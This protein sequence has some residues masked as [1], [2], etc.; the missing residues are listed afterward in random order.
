MT[1]S[2]WNEEKLEK[3]L[4]SMP[5]V[6]DDRD[7]D[8]LYE[9]VQQRTQKKKSAFHTPK[10]L[11]PSAAGVAILLIVALIVPQYLP[12]KN[13]ESALDSKQEATQLDEANMPQMDQQNGQE[14][15]SS[16]EDSGSSTMHIAGTN[17]SNILYEG[18]A[19][20]VI[21]FGLPDPEGKF[22][23][24]F[25][26]LV[27]NEEN[28]ADLL[29][30][31]SEW[32]D[33]AQYGLDSFVFANSDLAIK[34][35]EPGTMIID[36][37]ADH[38]FRFGSP[39]IEMLEMTVKT[40]QYM[41][42]TSA[43]LKT[44]GNPGIENEFYGEIKEMEIASLNK[45]AYFVYKYDGER[46]V[47]VPMPVN[48]PEAT[49]EKALEMMKSG[50]ANDS[51]LEPSIPEE[52]EIGGVAVTNKSGQVEIALEGAS[53]LPSEQEG[54]TMMEAILLTAKEFG[55]VEVIFTTEESQRIGP[56]D[57]NKPI[58]TPSA[59]NPIK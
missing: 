7:A 50:L 1:G 56:Y 10:W 2:K 54:V 30:N 45:S 20:R 27:Y 18:G 21:S 9:K 58:E 38:P 42:I 26:F 40:F 55:Y 14:Q 25:S 39:G 8:Q 49:F 48:G 37:P 4:N 57:M 5:T 51:P 17:E 35:S 23:V 44:E 36:V 24:P 59:P 11:F 33:P 28:P 53:D 16:A 6:D 3:L 43:E 13:S 29:M 41:G 19:G 34:E 15:S 46:M 32:I 22:V 52:V 12:V 31:I 47:L